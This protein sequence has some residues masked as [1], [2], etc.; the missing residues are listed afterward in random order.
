MTLT[1]RQLLA[2]LDEHGLR[3]SRALGQNFMVDPNT[4]RRM[5]R[6]AAVGPGDRVIEIGAGLGALTLALRET[7]AAVTAVE[8]DH[9]LVPVLRDIVEPAG[10]T[11][12]EAD[13]MTLDFGTV[14]GRHRGPWILAANLPYNV[15]TPLVARVLDEV[16]EIVRMLILVQREVGE[17]LAAATGDPAYGAISVKVAYWA[18]AKVVGRVGP[19]VFFPRPKVE[20]AIVAVERRVVPAV[21]PAHVPPDELFALVRAGFAQRRKMLRRSLAGVVGAE[22]FEAAGIDPSKRAEDLDVAAWGRLAACRTLL[23]PR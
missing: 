12:V 14:L 1:R 20:S 9:R 10:A 15:A 6:L 18:K 11:V 2:L 16:P 22:A 21:D 19:N 4:A 3:A 5:A 8:V 13:A 23:R 17:R 7:G